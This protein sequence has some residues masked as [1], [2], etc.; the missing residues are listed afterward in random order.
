M[1]REG[2]EGQGSGKRCMYLAGDHRVPHGGWVVAALIGRGDKVDVRC[3]DDGRARL[4]SL[5]ALA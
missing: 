3:Y 5:L 1:G 2:I 4:S